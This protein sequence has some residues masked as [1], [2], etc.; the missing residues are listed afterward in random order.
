MKTVL[1]KIIFTIFV[2]L[3]FI[4]CGSSG[5]GIDRG[6]YEPINNDTTK[7]GGSGGN[8]G[9][10]NG[11]GDMENQK[12]NEE[13][14]PPIAAPSQVLAPVATSF[15][16]DIRF[17]NIREIDEPEQQPQQ[18][19]GN[20]SQQQQSI[21]R[22]ASDYGGKDEDDSDDADENSDE[23]DS[24]ENSDED[25]S[26]DRDS[27]SDS[28]SD[29][30]TDNADD[31]D[32]NSDEDDAKDDDDDED[33][34]DE[35]DEEDDEDENDESNSNS[36]DS[37]ATNNH[38]SRPPSNTL[39]NFKILGYINV[40]L[41]YKKYDF[42]VAQSNYTN[43]EMKPKL[44]PL[45]N[46]KYHLSITGY[47]IEDD[48]LDIS[49]GVFT[50]EINNIDLNRESDWYPLEKNILTNSAVQPRLAYVTVDKKGDKVGLM[51]T[52]ERFLLYDRTKTQMYEAFFSVAATSEF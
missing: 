9:N 42:I 40:T 27:D 21:A 19:Q 32:E 50:I 3:S 47:M 38:D 2:S 31:T 24:D 28:D 25:D 34:E 11:N 37:A 49:A 17:F 41:Q 1:F 14:P 44:L 26:D 15:A 35:N 7:N 8:P 23:D 6:K 45:A 52:V 20:G 30:D 4:A 51:I 13:N 46:G 22:K 48:S 18:Q 43:Q 33:D 29:R 12:S 5:D 36:N 39:A 10:S 16:E